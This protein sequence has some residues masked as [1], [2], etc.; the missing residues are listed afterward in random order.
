MWVLDFYGNDASFP[1]L[2][3]VSK[4]AL[5][6]EIIN[7]ASFTSLN[8]PR[9]EFT[10]TR[11][12][13]EA[14]NHEDFSIDDLGTF[15]SIFHRCCVRNYVSGKSVIFTVVCFSKLVIFS[16]NCSTFGEKMFCQCRMKLQ[17]K[18]LWFW[19][20]VSSLKFLFLDVSCGHCA[21]LHNN[22]A[23][24]NIMLHFCF[25]NEIKI[26]CYIMFVT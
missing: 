14:V 25:E 22:V 26:E 21:Q 5:R 12:L 8:R 10:I 7:N 6:F 20:F 19:E 13:D 1:R 23:V 24:M 18:A 4:S 11:R 16:E 3:S 2:Q 9:L 17:C 15:C